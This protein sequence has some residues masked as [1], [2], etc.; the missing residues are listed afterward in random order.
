MKK[1]NF[2]TLRGQMA[3]VGIVLWFLLAAWSLSAFWQHIDELG[4]TYPKVT[5]LGAMA[6]EVALAALI[7][8]HCFSKHINVRK[9]SLIFSVALSAAILV[10][11][12]A[13][14]GMTEAHTAQLDAEKRL[15]ETLT[16]MSKE[17]MQSTRRR[18]E[19]AKAAQKEVADAVKGSADKVKDSSILPRWYLDGW[20]YSVLFILSLAFVGCAFW[21][22]MN[23]EDI[24]ANFDGIPDRLQQPAK[25][26]EYFDTVD[27]VPATGR[28]ETGK[29]SRR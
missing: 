5:K 24:D 26:A 7:W 13:L 2:I 28:L 4:A 19:V 8:W 10:H 12:G 11:A 23:R 15:A 14:R 18:A 6:G 29:D 16:K 27:E 22:M 25:T 20:M 1:E 9:W 3:F 17:Q 21:M